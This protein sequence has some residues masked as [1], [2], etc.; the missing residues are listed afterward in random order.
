MWPTISIDEVSPEEWGQIMA[1]TS[2][3]DHFFDPNLPDW[4]DFTIRSIVATIIYST[5]WKVNRIFSTSPNLLPRVKEI[6][7]AISTN[8]KQGLVLL[9]QLIADYSAHVHSQSF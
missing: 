2:P 8:P 5:P 7:E 9:K 1:D 6:K 3:F 4:A